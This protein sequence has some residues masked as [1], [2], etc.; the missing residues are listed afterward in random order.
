MT[1]AVVDTLNIVYPI[2]KDIHALEI[3]YHLHFYLITTS[4]R[5]MLEYFTH[6][7]IKN[8]I[9]LSHLCFF[10][11]GC[12]YNLITSWSQWDYMWQDM[13]H[14]RVILTHML[15]TIALTVN[16]P[17]TLIS[18]NVIESFIES[19]NVIFPEPAWRAAICMFIHS[20]QPKETMMKGTRRTSHIFCV[21]SRKVNTAAE[22]AHYT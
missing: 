19:W 17:W 14:M 18:W 11:L 10:S 13:L 21:E 15:A 20:L 2:H 22:T 16:L 3:A 1:I 12:V 4:S 8:D 6:P 5:E 9:P 7:D